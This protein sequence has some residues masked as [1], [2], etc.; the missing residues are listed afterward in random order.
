MPSFDVVSKVDMQEVKNALDH[1]RREIENR[2][3]FKGSKASVELKENDVIVMADDQMKLK[4][5]QEI[6][7]LKFAKRSVSLKSV[8]WEEPAAAG[9][10]ML[11]QLVKVKQGLNDEELK[12]VSKEIKNAKLKVT[13][14]VQG[15]QVRVTGKK[16]DDL[17]TAMQHLR[18]AMPKVDLQFIN[19]RD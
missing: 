9:G 2:Y 1:T 18:T 4:A 16:R 15:N 6:L 13:T 8:E 12:Q 5:L 14:Q 17:Q 11:R 10:D 7:R 19:F 3:D